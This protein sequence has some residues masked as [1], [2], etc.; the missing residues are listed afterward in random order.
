MEFVTK[1]EGAL[2]STFPAPDP[3]HLEDNDGIVGRVASGRFR[4]L[5]FIDRINRTWDALDRE[6]TPDER[7]RVVTI[8]AVTPEEEIAHRARGAPART[9][10]N[11]RKG[12]S[13][14]S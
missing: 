2:R 6:L 1:V 9:G 8:V 5:E 10:R 12:R 11:R 3:I 7:R 14:S 13:Q 4:G